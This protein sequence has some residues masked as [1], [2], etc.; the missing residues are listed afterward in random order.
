MGE[1]NFALSGEGG[2]GAIL[3]VMGM[4]VLGLVESQQ[5]QVPYAVVYH[6]QPAPQRECPPLSCFVLTVK[7]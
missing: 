5:Q 1:V 7:C 2:I 3:V 4:H 6:P